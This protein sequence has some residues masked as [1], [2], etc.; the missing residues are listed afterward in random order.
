MTLNRKTIYNIGKVLLTGFLLFVLLKDVDFQQISDLISNTNLLLYLLVYLLFLFGTVISGVRWRILLKIQGVDIKLGKLV[1]KILISTVYNLL[2]P[3]S[4][5]GDIIRTYDVTTQ[6]KENKAGTLLA[7]IYDKFLGLF[8]LLF[9]IILS[10]PFIWNEIEQKLI[11]FGLT[12]VSGGV[13]FS[14]VLYSGKVPFIY[15]IVSWFSEKLK[16]SRLVDDGI[17]AFSEFK[18]NPRATIYGLSLSSFFQ[19][20]GVINQFLL[21]KALGVDVDFGLL[22]FAIPINRLITLI[23]ISIGGIGLR[24]TSL[25][26]LLSSSGIMPTQIAAY[27]LLKYSMN[28]FLPLM[29]LGLISVKRVRNYLEKSLYNK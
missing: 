9:V 8:S 28:I 7:T 14:L 6:T 17:S 10:L 5:G 11:L 3:G 27:S 4:M 13:A 18:G 2:L 25:L 22:M 21:F 19:L 29:I 24:E 26:V 16:V 20:L 1:N 23:P 12:L 15:R